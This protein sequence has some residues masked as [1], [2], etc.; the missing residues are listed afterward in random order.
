MKSIQS[1]LQEVKAK[2]DL[3]QD[4]PSNISL[5][6]LKVESLAKEIVIYIF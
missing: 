2:L 3:Y 1:D 6:Q 5:A 4:L